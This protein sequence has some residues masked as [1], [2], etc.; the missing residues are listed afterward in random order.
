MFAEFYSGLWLDDKYEHVT[1]HQRQRNH[2]KS[3]VPVSTALVS[4]LPRIEI[5][6]SH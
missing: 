4:I 5:M 6:Y 1:G 2:Q 3:H